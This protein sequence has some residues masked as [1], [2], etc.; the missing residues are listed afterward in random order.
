MRA[1]SP[2]GPEVSE[3]ASRSPRSPARAHTGPYCA[4]HCATQAGP[5]AYQAQ[6]LAGRRGYAPRRGGAQCAPGATARLRLYRGRR[7]GRTEQRP[8][9]ISNPA[10]RR[11]CTH[12]LHPR[13]R[14]A[15]AHGRRRRA[16]GPHRVLRMGPI[17][18]QSPAGSARCGR[19]AARAGCPGVAAPPGP[20]RPC[21]RRDVASVRE[22]P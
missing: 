3:A 18:M 22:P 21:L 1:R 11:V 12:A 19:P 17:L 15:I 8:D 9:V 4:T 10:G 7:R 13:H 2:A 14:P 5:L 16:G 20:A 6:W